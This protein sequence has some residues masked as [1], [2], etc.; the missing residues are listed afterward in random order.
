MLTCRF[1]YVLMRVA[2]V[3]MSDPSFISLAPHLGYYCHLSQFTLSSFMLPCQTAISYS[4]PASVAECSPTAHIVC[5]KCNFLLKS[6]CLF[7]LLISKTLQENCFN[8]YK[9]S[10]KNV[11]KFKTLIFFWIKNILEQLHDCAWLLR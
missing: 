6:V 11:I 9:L 4:F 2:K 3:H 5:N 1:T 7:Q 8:I 10:S